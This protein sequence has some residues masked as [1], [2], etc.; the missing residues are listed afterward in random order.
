[1]AGVKGRSGPRHG[2][3]AKAFRDF[4]RDVISDKIVLDLLRKTARVDPVFALRLAEHGIGRPYQAVHV[5][6]ER[7]DGL[8]RSEFSDSKPVHPAAATQLPDG[9]RA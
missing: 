1:M 9:A 3:K 6:T 2:A 8:Y 5:T 7:V 4:C